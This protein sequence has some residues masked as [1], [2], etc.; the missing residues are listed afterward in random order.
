[1]IYMNMDV[2][3]MK[4]NYYVTLRVDARYQTEVQAEN[5]EEAK[6]KAMSNWFDADIGDLEETEGEIVC[7]ENEEGDFVYEE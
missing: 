1:M 7:V 2:V 4:E 3:N 5:V 6:E